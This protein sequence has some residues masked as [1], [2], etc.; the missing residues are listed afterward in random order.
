MERTDTGGLGLKV[1]RYT[2]KVAENPIKGAW[3]GGATYYEWFFET[4]ANGGI[5]EHK[6]KIPVWK[7]GPLLR[8][9]GQKEV[10]PDIF[11]WD[12]EG[13]TGLEFDGEIVMEWNKD[14][15]KAYPRIANHR[16]AGSVP[17]EKD[18]AVPF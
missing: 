13:V 11:E 2:F 18:D 10:E 17:A 15:T 16:K 3:G 6:E 1:G 14:K 5:T 4:F 7:M 8:A 9:L 12:R